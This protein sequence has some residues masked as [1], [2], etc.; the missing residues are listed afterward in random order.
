M[1]DQ[2]AADEHDFNHHPD[3][4]QA[5]RQIKHGDNEDLLARLRRR[6]AGND[7]RGQ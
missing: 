3:N 1:P 6:R 7:G 2:H 4:D 5:D